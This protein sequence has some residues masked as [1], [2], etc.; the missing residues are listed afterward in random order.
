MNYKNITN[1]LREYVS[2]DY[3]EA[4]NLVKEIFKNNIKIYSDSSGTFLYEEQH[5][6]WIKT[7]FQTSSLSQFIM[8]LRAIKS[9]KEYI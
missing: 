7:I 1:Q 5:G 9:C 2:K 3:I 8:C 4:N 6:T